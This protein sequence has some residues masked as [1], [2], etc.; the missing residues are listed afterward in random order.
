MASTLDATFAVVAADGA[1]VAT[2]GASAAFCDAAFVVSTP[3]TTAGAVTI[4]L[5]S[6]LWVLACEGGC[7]S[8][9]ALDS[10]EISLSTGAGGR[11]AGASRSARVPASPAMTTNCRTMIASSHGVDLNPVRGVIRGT[12]G[13]RVPTAWLVS[14]S[15]PGG[16]E[17]WPG[18]TFVCTAAPGPRITPCIV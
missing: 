11:G 15:A 6:G 10:A 5:A 3:A 2:T 16:R 17:V 12:T 13:T 4:T 8:G 18:G 1:V 14:G 9:D 7:R